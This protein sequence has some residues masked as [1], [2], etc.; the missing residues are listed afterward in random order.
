TAGDS[1]SAVLE[2]WSLPRPDPFPEALAFQDVV[3]ALAARGLALISIHDGDVA[4]LRMLGQPALLT[5]DAA[6]GV[7]RVVAVRR[8]AGADVGLAG[9]LPRP[10]PRVAARG[11]ARGWARAGPR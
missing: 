11:A 5:V 8:L 6:D 7:P 1:L 10:P 4:R 2:A 9:G 3:S